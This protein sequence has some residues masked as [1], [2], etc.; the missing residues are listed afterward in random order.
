[1]ENQ[2]ELS[3]IE[4]SATKVDAETTDQT[5]QESLHEEESSVV[6]ND[7]EEANPNDNEVLVPEQNLIESRIDLSDEQTAQ[8]DLNLTPSV[9]VTESA[10]FLT[11][12]Q[13]SYAQTQQQQDQVIAESVVIEKSDL[14]SQ[15]NL[16]D[17]GEIELTKEQQ[18]QQ[19][20]SDSNNDEEKIELLNLSSTNSRVT[21]VDE[22]ERMVKNDYE[23]VSRSQI[24][25]AIDREIESKYDQ[26]KTTPIIPIIIYIYI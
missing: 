26:C 13:I 23:H 4:Q 20:A 12:S 17:N 10:V 15:L 2:Q 9:S 16:L 1:M 8:S 18:Q 14:E 24:E 22:V 7:E 5:K 3:A 6:H 19:Q 21:P 11:Q 25:E